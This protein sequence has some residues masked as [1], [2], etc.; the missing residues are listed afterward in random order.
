VSVAL[1]QGN[2]LQVQ[3]NAL[4]AMFFWP[5]LPLAQAI[6]T[7]PTQQVIIQPEVPLPENELDLPE[8]PTSI[9]LNTVMQPQQ[10]RVLPNSTAF[11][12][13]TATAP[14]LCKRKAFCFPHFPRKENK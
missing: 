14:K 6:P 7:P 9:P 13:S 8:P 12:F 3:L 2:L 11:R 5:T 1:R 4:T 10:V